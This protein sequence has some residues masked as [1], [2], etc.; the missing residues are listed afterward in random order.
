MVRSFRSDVGLVVSSCFW[1][2][3]V[4]LAAGMRIGG[5]FVLI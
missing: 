4:W 5:S 3:G 2:L 1:T